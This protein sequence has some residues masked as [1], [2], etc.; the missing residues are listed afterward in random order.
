MEGDTVSRIEVTVGDDDA[1]QRLDAWL[2]G[3]VP[4]LSRSR[5]KA[6]IAGGSVAV[7]GATIEEPKRPVKPGDRVTVALPPP[8]PAEEAL[9]AMRV[10]EAGIASAAQRREVPFAVA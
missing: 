10:I 6:L 3:A 4:D 7:G 5:A 2:A 9:L 8:V 1:G